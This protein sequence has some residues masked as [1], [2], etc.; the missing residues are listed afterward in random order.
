[1]AGGLL[2][3][4]SNRLEDL[5]TVLAKRLDESPLPPLADE[6]I[7]VPGQGIARWLRF[8]LAERHGIAAGLELQFPGAF[9][10]QLGRSID[11]GQRDV[12]TASTLTWRIHRLLGDAALQREL[13]LAA[14]YCE[15]DADG[16]KR[17]QLAQRLASCFDD[18]QL[19]RADLLAE[20]ADGN[21]LEKAGPHGP[22]QA[23]LWRALLHDAGF[24]HDAAQAPSSPPLLFPELADDQ[25]GAW[26]AHRL[27]RLERLFAD[28]ARAAS[29][30]P[31]R[32]SIFATSTLPPTL[33]RLLPSIAEHIPVLLYVPMPSPHYFGDQ[34]P[35]EITGNRLLANLGAEVRE[36]QDALVELETNHANLAIQ[37]VDLAELPDTAPHSMLEC[38]QHDLAWVRQHGESE[39]LPRYP[40]VA[41]D[42]S[43]RVHDC[44][45]E[46]RELEV[47]RDQILDA[48]AADAT[49]Q[50]HEILVLVPDIERYSPYV[51]AVFGPLQR[52][53]PY[54]VADKSPVAEQPVCAALIRV[55]QL[56]QSRLQ[57][58]DVLHLLETPAI[59]RRFGLFTSDLPT[60]RHLCE[61]AGIRWGWDGASR[62]RRFAVPAFDDNS[63]R[64]GIERMLYGVATGPTTDVVLG[65]LPAADV[66][67]GREPLLGRLLEFL[68]VLFAHVQ[69][70]QQP[71]ALAGWADRLEALVAALFTPDAEDEPGLDA[72]HAASAGLRALAADARHNEPITPVVLRDWLTGT[73]G[74]A[75][76]GQGFLGGR[77]TVAAMLPMRTVPVRHLFLCGLDDQSFPRRDQPAAFDLTQLERRPGDRSFRLDDRQMFL[78]C[79]LAARERLHITFI[80]HSAKDDSE[81]APSVVLSELIDAIEDAC[82]PPAGYARPRDWLVARHPLQAWSPRY[83]DQ[84]DPR[85]HTYGVS[86]TPA[87]PIA[88]RTGSAWFTDPITP[89]NPL[90]LEEITLDRL[91]DFWWH[92][93]RFFLVHGLGI[94][95]PRD[96]DIDFTTEAFAVHPLHNWRLLNDAIRRQLGDDE[97]LRDALAYT[98]ATG[99]LPAGGAGV[100]A[101]AQVEEAKLQFLGELKRRGRLTAA[102][103]TAQGSDFRLTGSIEHIGTDAVIYA[104]AA[105]VKPKDRLKAWVL[106]VV[107]SSAR[108]QGAALPPRTTAILRD[109]TLGYRELLAEE[110][111]EHLATLVEGYRRGQREPLPFFENSSQAYGKS[112][113]KRPAQ[114]AAALRSARSSWLPGNAQFASSD[115]EDAAIALCMRGREPLDLDDFATWARRV[116]CPAYDCTE[117]AR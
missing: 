65:H 89:T 23:R 82:A 7:L 37:R 45:S 42:D 19:Y 53:L 71:H 69:Q 84:S 29:A 103:I 74:R 9:L 93:C 11:D 64:Q 49:L 83:R 18:Y 92:P 41:L 76:S 88:S 90:P 59:Q 94:R 109:A 12:F 3:Y 105:K 16:C 33:L 60:L 70:L 114:S 99:M 44:H 20:A 108:L 21:D 61:R 32:L 10:Q 96:N 85:L 111:T 26:Q 81:C 97:P 56:A 50:P 51:N 63:W 5:L 102:E 35:R 17:F 79:L 27:Q 112:L 15:D 62:E 68:D 14:R 46:H 47:V 87:E 40:I 1:M 95:L 66:T 55:L 77:V 78:D 54:R 30:L 72:L 57:V 75:A 67:S 91:L 104:R 101:F 107:A 106:H 22:W 98:R 4:T 100:A 38:V 80:G 24:Q 25:G 43:L 115:S 116:W 28:P 86:G 110:A 2:I 48:F 113:Q 73:L 58:Y 39:E 13:G 52:W 8:E 31:Q 36:L 117:T 6:T 34:H